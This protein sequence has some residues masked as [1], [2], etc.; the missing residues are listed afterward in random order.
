MSPK[1]PHSQKHLSLSLLQLRQLLYNPL[2]TSLCPALPPLV[3][4]YLP[5][6]QPYLPLSCF[7][8]PCPALPPPCPAL[9]PF[10]LVY[11][12]LPCLTSPCPA[13]PPPCPALSPFVLVYL[14]LPVPYL[15][16]VL[17]Y[18]DVV[19]QGGGHCKEGWDRAG[20]TVKMD[21]TRQGTL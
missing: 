1:D 21:G 8:S 6:A 12:F 11:L 14:L 18:Q 9:H 4:P 5:I 17:L 20:D 16:H 2:L 3:L 15:P 19:G 10:L 13:L 7:T